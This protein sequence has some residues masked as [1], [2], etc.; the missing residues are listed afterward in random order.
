[1]RILLTILS[2]AVVTAFALARPAASPLPNPL[3]G[4]DFEEC[5]QLVQGPVC[6]QFAADDGNNYYLENLSVFGPGDRVRV[7]GALF[8]STG[9]C[10][11]FQCTGNYDGC[12]IGNLIEP[13]VPAVPFCFGD[14]G[15]SPGCTQCRCG[16][17][18]AP[19]SQGGCINSVGSSGQLVAF[20]EGRI[21]DD[22]LRFE[23]RDVSPNT[24][25]VLVSG[26]NALPNNGV[27]PP[28]AGIAA[29]EFD[30]L[31]CVGGALRRHGTR[32]TDSM[33]SVGET[34]PGWGP[35]D[36][37]GGGIAG[38]AGFVAGQTRHFQMIYRDDE[39]LVCMS[40]LNTTNAA[41]VL[42]VP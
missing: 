27:C 1:M 12:I 11:P 41:E 6:V 32:P 2:L 14:G 7:V 24:F 9:L 30:G 8:T 33:G 22:T 21:S 20:G 25:A 39:T 5:G 15:V 3:G 26:D 23:G 34:T 28:G 19:G 37:P 10:L 42:F 4:G 36:G 31:R 38:Q 35:P 40:G 17:D 13:C 16:N 18:A 29:M